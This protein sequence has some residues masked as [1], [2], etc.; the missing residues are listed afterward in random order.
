MQE[1]G[2][3][4]EK[5]EDDGHMQPT[6]A[7]PPADNHQQPHYQIRPA[8]ILDQDCNGPWPTTDHW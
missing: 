5:E 3:K 4:P 8:T 6:I 7:T 2:K 1:T